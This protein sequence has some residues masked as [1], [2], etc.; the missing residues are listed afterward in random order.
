MLFSTVDS[1]SVT[2]VQ[3]P[4][5]FGNHNYQTVR[6]ERKQTNRNSRSGFRRSE[7]PYSDESIKESQILNFI[8]NSSER[9]CTKSDI[10]QTITL[11]DFHFKFESSS[12]RRYSK[13]VEKGKFISKSLTDLF[14]KND[15][16]DSELRS[17][18]G[19]HV[20][21]MMAVLR[22]IVKDDPHIA[23]GGVAFNTNF[24]PYIYKSDD[25]TESQ[26]KDLSETYSNFTHYGFYP[27]H[28]TRDY[29]K[30]TEDLDDYLVWDEPY[31]ECYR[32]KRW[33]AGLS[34]PFFRN[35]SES[36]REFR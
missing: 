11:N 24:F 5:K 12:Y 25:N 9:N 31:F 29:S 13:Q 19:K 10:L 4:S 20:P 8:E 6:S 17:F 1:L 27:E 36:K 14:Y 34:L 30:S 16:P 33:I 21:A 28:S 18:N 32:L 7:L 15:I 35:T 3:F 23:G 2:D 26:S 22:V